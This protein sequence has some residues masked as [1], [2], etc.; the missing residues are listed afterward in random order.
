M[1]IIHSWS[2]ES[3]KLRMSASSTQ[4]IRSFIRAV[5][6]VQRLM[7]VPPRPEAVAEPKKVDFVDGAQH[8]GHRTL[9]DL[10]LQGRYAERPPPAV[11]FGDGGAAHR[12]WPVSPGV[13]PVAEVP[14]IASRFCS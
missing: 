3:K 6:R 14:N 11:G 5:W 10:V 4:L 7:G 2:T 12:L 1:R 13:N 8:L 9:D